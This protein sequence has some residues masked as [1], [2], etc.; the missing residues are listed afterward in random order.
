MKTTYSFLLLIILLAS[1]C[2]STEIVSTKKLTDGFCIV[3]NDQVILN[4]Y[5]IE[6]Y[7]YSTHL[8]YMKNNMSFDDDIE[9]ME[10]FTVTANGEDIYSGQTLPSYSSFMP[11]GPV[12]YTHP[13]FYGDHIIAIGFIQITDT[14]GNTTPDPRED[15][16]IVEALN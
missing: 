16:R 10:T 6:Y 12:I 11:S 1:G 15:E 7:D 8:I 4:H 2:D 5:N 14:L 9:I 3:S 13:T